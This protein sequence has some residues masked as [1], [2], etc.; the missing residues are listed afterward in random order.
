MDNGVVLMPGVSVNNLDGAFA[1]VEGRNFRPWPDVPSGTAVQSEH[2]QGVELADSDARALPE[3]VVYE[4]IN[5]GG[6]SWRTNLNYFYVGGWWNDRISA[7]VIVR[8]TW[9]FYQ[10]RDYRGRFWD[11][12]G[13][14]YY[15][16]VVAAGI[17]NDIISSFRCIAL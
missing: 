4:H 11:L 5:F 16:W 10:D 8:G 9:R 12:R 13:P 3:I 6:A 7:I 2:G 1:D 14:G 17:P 15:P